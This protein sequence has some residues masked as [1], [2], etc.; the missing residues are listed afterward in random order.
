MWFTPQRPYHEP[1]SSCSE[2]SHSS[3][4]SAASRWDPSV[5]KVS[6]VCAVTSALGSSVTLP[7]SQNGILYSH[8]ALLSTSKEPQ[9]P[10]LDCMPTSQSRLRSIASPPMPSSWSASATTA[11]SSTSG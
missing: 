3:P 2:S 1:S 8:I 9:P 10:S 6:S 11:A 5:P 4:L 7:K